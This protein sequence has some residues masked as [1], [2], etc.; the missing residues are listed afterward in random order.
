[1]EPKD[2]MMRA[3]EGAKSSL[4]PPQW[5]R[6]QS[7]PKNERAVLGSRPLAFLATRLG[8]QVVGAMLCP[9]TAMSIDFWNHSNSI[10]N[11]AKGLRAL[12]GSSLALQRGKVPSQCF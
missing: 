7:R 2:F 5:V 1:M 12:S 8:L 11:S 10:P 6:E 3:L 4:H 9:P